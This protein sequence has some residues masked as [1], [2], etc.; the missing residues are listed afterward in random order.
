MQASMQAAF[1]ETDSDTAETNLN[2]IGSRTQM[3]M[4]LK[5]FEHPH[6][7]FQ[8]KHKPRAFKSQIRNISKEVTFVHGQRSP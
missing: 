7:F 2:R 3:K 5:M 6:L 1:N 8:E 4:S